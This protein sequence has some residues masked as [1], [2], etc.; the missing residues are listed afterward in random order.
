MVTQA[1]GRARRDP[2]RFVDSSE[3]VV[4]RMDRNHSHVIL[5]LLAETILSIW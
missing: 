5:N 1:S 3:I 2:Q 4:D